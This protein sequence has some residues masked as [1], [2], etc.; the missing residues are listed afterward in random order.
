MSSNLD[1]RERTIQLIGPGFRDD[2]WVSIEKI[3]S[4]AGYSSEISTEAKSLECIENFYFGIAI[5]ATFK[6]NECIRKKA[7]KGIFVFHSSDL[8]FGRGWAPIYWT[9]MENNN[10][11][12]SMLKAS[13]GID[14]G[15]IICK[16]TLP[17]CGWETEREVRHLD[18][19]LT[20][21]MI[22]K[23][24]SKLAKEGDVTIG[25]FQEDGGSWNKKRIPSDSKV[26]LDEDAKFLSR[27]LRAVPD[28]APAYTYINGR[29]FIISVKE[30][31]QQ[32]WINL[33]LQERTKFAE[34]KFFSCSDD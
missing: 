33:S 6:I 18:K 3:L 9:I 15:P 16:G 14:Q 28:S 24:L 8:P 31:D 1:Y 21:I 4:Q 22:E 26:T 17:L 12:I 27:F 32:S 29:K 7:K 10:L 25:V 13:E 34:I 2:A 5:N 20:I 11:V 19:A 23:F 30:A